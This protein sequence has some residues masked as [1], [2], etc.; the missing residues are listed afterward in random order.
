[1]LLIYGLAK[2]VAGMLLHSYQHCITAV[3]IMPVGARRVC[4]SVCLSLCHGA[5]EW[6]YM[7]FYSQ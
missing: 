3:Y 6:L 5:L 7:M 1:M 4:L 2:G